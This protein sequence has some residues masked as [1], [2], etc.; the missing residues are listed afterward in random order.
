MTESMESI[1]F[2]D[3]KFNHVVSGEYIFNNVLKNWSGTDDT[4]DCHRLHVLSSTNSA[5]FPNPF[6]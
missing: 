4:S 5:Q 3:R 1:Q 6:F 2:N